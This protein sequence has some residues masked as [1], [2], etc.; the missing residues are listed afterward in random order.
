MEKLRLESKADL[1]H[2]VARFAAALALLTAPAAGQDTPRS[3]P[4]AVEATLGDTGCR[5]FRPPIDGFQPGDLGPQL[6]FICSIEDASS[7]A[8]TGGSLDSSQSTLSVSQYRVVSNRVAR[9]R[10]EKDDRSSQRPR[11]SRRRSD[12]N[13]LFADLGHSDAHTFFT[14]REAQNQTNNFDVGRLGFSASFGHTDLDKEA[15]ALEDAYVSDL[16]DRAVAFDIAFENGFILGV[17]FAA[18]DQDGDNLGLD[19][20]G[21]QDSNFQVSLSSLIFDECATRGEPGLSDGFRAGGQFERSEVAGG[22]YAGFTPPGT[23]HFGVL[24]MSVGS[25]TYKYDRNTCRVLTSSGVVS[26]DTLGESGVF[27]GVISAEADFTTLNL[28]SLIGTAFAAGPIVLSPSF[29]V[30][31]SRRETD[32]YS[33]TGIAVVN[34]AGFTTSPRFIVAGQDPTGLELLYEEQEETSLVTSA[35]L[36]ANTNHYRGSVLIQPSVTVGYQ[37]QFEDDARAVSV[38]FVQDLRSEP[39]SFTFDTEGPD[40]NAGFVNLGISARWQS[41]WA[42]RAGYLRYFADDRFDER[43]FNVGMRRSF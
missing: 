25:G 8:T 4:E 1:I 23:N 19:F 11:R 17:S 18:S 26:P 3:L 7:A 21:G 20:G 9:R 34:D 37:Y 6:D 13:V 5:N 36:T 22:L 12:A 16:I 38:Q 10:A 35:S 2:A 32:D 29:G 33:E 24:A 30:R 42:I 41:G 15:S 43:G 31:W 39:V 40:R 27:G 14:V 28:D